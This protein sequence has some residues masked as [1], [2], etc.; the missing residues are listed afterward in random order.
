MTSR[1]IRGAAALLLCGAMIGAGCPASSQD[2]PGLRFLGAAE[3]ATGTRFEGTEIGGLSG[4]AWRGGDAWLAISDDG[5]DPRV[6]D[7]TLTLQEER[8]G[9]GSIRID[10]VRRLT[11]AGGGRFKPPLDPEAIAL[12]PGGWIYVAD[13]GYTWK[14]HPSQVRIFNGDFASRGS[15]APPPKIRPDGF[16][17]DLGSRG[18]RRK[19]GFESIAIT[20]DGRRLF[21]AVEQAL[22]QDG[23]A[24][25]PAIGSRTRLFSYDLESGAAGP[26]YAYPLA[27]VPG[28][29][30]LPLAQEAAG[31]VGLLALDNA[32]GFL[33]LERSFTLSTGFSVRLFR[34]DT[35]G[36]TDV[37]GDF[38]LPE[39]AIPVRKRELLDLA[40]LGIELDNME[41]MALGPEL[42]TGERLLL[43]VSDNNF[44]ARQRTLFLAFGFLPDAEQRAALDPSEARA[45]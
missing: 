2:A 44:R 25:G 42:A 20:P 12:G 37:S 38:V 31:L 21:T 5:A 30:P 22:L 28:M 4:L 24:V 7:F 10:A 17:N 8:L 1:F 33:A 9:A 14:G 13:E 3:I 43:L 16:R 23:P 26:E 11:P 19:F 34:V 18:V 27:P 39:D 36:A 29:L 32:G 41:G 35:A 40:N 6:Y 15:L 45:D